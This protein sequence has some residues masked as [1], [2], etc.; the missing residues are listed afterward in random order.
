MIC[1]IKKMHS[2]HQD[3]QPIQGA[4]RMKFKQIFAL[5]MLIILALALALSLPPAAWASSG[6]AFVGPA[7]FSAA[8]AT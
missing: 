2:T 3:F 8:G 5:S 6:W 7:D 4:D 1:P